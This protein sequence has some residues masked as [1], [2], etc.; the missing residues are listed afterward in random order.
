MVSKN[1]EGI[2][3][4]SFS[5]KELDVI[6]HEN[7]LPC[8]TMLNFGHFAA[9]I[10]IE[11]GGLRGNYSHQMWGVN[12]H[13]CLKLDGNFTKPPLSYGLDDQLH[14][15][16]V[17]LSIITHGLIEI[18]FHRNVKEP[19]C[20]R[21]LW[22]GVAGLILGLRTTSGRRRYNVTPSLTGW[23]QTLE[24]ALSSNM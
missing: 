8:I 2:L 3:C 23:A 1:C 16:V 24:S 12:I 9:H 6:V 14:P 11:S 5:V 4:S 10:T 7:Y 13:P 17:L 20:T 21:R 22:K 19:Y 15:I 18:L